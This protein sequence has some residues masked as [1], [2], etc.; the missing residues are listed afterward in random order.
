MRRIIVGLVGQN[1]C[2]K[3]TVA[4]TLE[5]E[6]EF[7]HTSLSDRIR[8]EL[9]RRGLEEVRDL[10]VEVGNEL[11]ERFGPDILARRTE[12]L[13]KEKDPE[14]VVID[15]IRNPEEVRYIKEMGGVIVGVEASPEK[16][17]ELMK[18]RGGRGDAKTWEEFLRLDNQENQT[19][20]ENYVQKTS[21][22]LKMAD[23]TINN[24]GTREE[25]VRKIRTDL[26]PRLL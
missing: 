17:F 5:E 26:I 20:G 24:D 21:E 10:M 9:N 13:I 16:R 22:C 25:L 7:F 12:E 11:R 15:S 18:V 19:G 14:R 3:G 8:E 23:I 4:K 6:Y 1:V 2:G